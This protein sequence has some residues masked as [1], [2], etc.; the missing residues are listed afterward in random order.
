MM[1]IKN[2]WFEFSVYKNKEEQKLIVHWWCNVPKIPF[3]CI[4]YAKTKIQHQLVFCG[5]DNLYWVFSKICEGKYKFLYK[6]TNDHCS[7]G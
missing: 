3:E 1:K 4:E 5:R 7:C 2:K 6:T